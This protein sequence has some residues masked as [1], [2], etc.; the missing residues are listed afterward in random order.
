MLHNINIIVIC[1]ITF[2]TNGVYCSLQ[3]L[4][5]HLH[6]FCLVDIL[7]FWTFINYQI[8][9]ITLTYCW[10]LFCYIHFVLFGRLLAFTCLK[11]SEC[12]I[13]I[14][15]NSW[16]NLFS[17]I[18]NWM[19]LSDLERPYWHWH[20]YSTL[21]VITY[22]SCFCSLIWYVPC[23]RTCVF[24]QCY[25]SIVLINIFLCTCLIFHDLYLD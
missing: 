22:Y 21:N 3:S 4:P 1:T 18:C 11:L 16:Y 10:H 13:F 9:L 17:V 6:Y 5:E 7:Y 19:T 25:L 20:C 15:S 23:D 14:K 2:L 12:L 8:P 24:L